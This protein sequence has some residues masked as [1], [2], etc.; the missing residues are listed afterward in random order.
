LSLAALPEGEPADLLFAFP[1]AAGRRFAL[2]VGFR[3][4][5]PES[6][7]RRLAT[8]ATAARRR[9]RSSPLEG[10]TF[11]TFMEGPS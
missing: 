8:Q 9:L 5:S 3:A 7:P 10:A 4:P 2:P 11:F 1:R 6:E